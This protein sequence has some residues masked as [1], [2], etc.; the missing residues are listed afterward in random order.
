M[1]VWSPHKVFPSTH[2]DQALRRLLCSGFCVCS[3]GEL[4][5]HRLCQ[6]Q[7]SVRERVPG[8]CQVLGLG[9]SDG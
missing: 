4:R 7:R 9:G 6:K 2:K 3:N 5:A 1:S 8:R